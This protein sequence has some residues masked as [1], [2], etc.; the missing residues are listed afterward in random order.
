[1]DFVWFPL[2]MKG[3][4]YHCCIRSVILCG[5]E[6]WCSKENEKAILRRMERATLRAMCGQ[7][8]VDRMTTEE[9]MSLLVL[10]KI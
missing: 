3:K 10:R 4:V 8:V 5:S 6:A 1:M 9:Q 2:R 7:K